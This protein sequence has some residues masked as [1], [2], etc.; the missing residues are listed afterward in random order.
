MPKT[1]IFVSFDYDTDYELKETLIGQA[2]LADSPF[3]V[4]DFSLRERQPESE[5]RRK[6]QSA[7]ARCDVF[8]TILGQNTHSAQGVLDE[9]A[10]ARELRKRRFQLRPQGK[11][12][13]EMKG[14]GKLVVWTWANLQRE[15]ATR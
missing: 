5:W 9:I 11:R 6:A 13:S 14:A 3:S 10:I 7:I 4:S 15:L 2:R 12:W 1:K 8:V